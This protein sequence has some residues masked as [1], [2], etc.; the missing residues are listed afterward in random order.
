M[1][2]HVLAN[3]AG[4]VEDVEITN[5]G[6][7]SNKEINTNII[8]EGPKQSISMKKVKFCQQSTL[9]MKL[10]NISTSPNHF[11]SGQINKQS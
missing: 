4:M 11:C 1:I 5:C 6:T 2:Q 8:P 7:K 9:F 3:A 10:F